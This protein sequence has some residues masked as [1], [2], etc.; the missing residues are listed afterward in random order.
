MRVRAPSGD[1][2]G[3]HGSGLVVLN[4]P[5]TLHDALAAAL[6]FLAEALRDDAGAGFTLERQAM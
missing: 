1:G 4:P 3:M 6:P 5:W 2:F